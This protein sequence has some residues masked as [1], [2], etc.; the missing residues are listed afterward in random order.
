M[1]FLPREGKN[2]RGAGRYYD[3][4]GY[5]RSS[6]LFWDNLGNYSYIPLHS[7]FGWDNSFFDFSFMRDNFLF[8]LILSNNEA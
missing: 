7:L 3:G 5:T 6:Y 1:F 2:R 8:I 4:T